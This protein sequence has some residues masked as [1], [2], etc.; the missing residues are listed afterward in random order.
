M[1]QP[2]LGHSHTHPC[3]IFFVIASFDQ[4]QKL[5]QTT[6][7]Q[8]ALSVMTQVIYAGSSVKTVL[9][10]LTAPKDQIYRLPVLRE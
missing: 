7:A 5:V 1:S 2:S 8:L 6:H 9:Q 4:V 3:V 10:D